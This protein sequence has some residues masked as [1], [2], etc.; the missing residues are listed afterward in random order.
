MA[1]SILGRIV[2]VETCSFHSLLTPINRLSVSSDGSWWLK[3]RLIPMP[4]GRRFFLSVSSDGS[5]WLKPGRRPRSSFAT[6]P[7][8]ILGRI[9]VVE[10][11]FRTWVCRAWFAFSILGR[12]VVVETIPAALADYNSRFFQYPRTDRGG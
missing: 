8:S 1:F 7:F 5:W 2:V 10:T 11:E 12:I 6:S 4:P 3:R 9:V